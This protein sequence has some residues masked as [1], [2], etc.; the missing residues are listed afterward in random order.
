MIF[1]GLPPT[2]VRGATSRVTTAPAAIT[3]QSPTVTPGRIVA[4]PPIQTLLPMVT[5]FGPFYACVALLRVKRMACCIYTYI[6]SDKHMIA[7]CYARLIENRQIEI[8]KEILA[9]AY[10]ASV[11]AA[12]RAVEMKTFAAVSQHVSDDFVPSRC[13]AW[14]YRVEFPKKLAGQLE[15]F[16]ELGVDSVIDFAVKHFLPFFF[17]ICCHSY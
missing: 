7:D 4:P 13:L 14:V 8:G 3:A 6:R 5:G 11:V 12:K 17:K 1:A 15:A 10:I 2:T 9:D 16:D